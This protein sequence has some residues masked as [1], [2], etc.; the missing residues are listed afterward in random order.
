MTTTVA[1][2]KRLNAG[3]VTDVR[4]A[5]A[6]SLSKD[7]LSVIREVGLEPVLIDQPP[8]D[9]TS[10]AAVV[11]PGGGDI[12]PARYGGRQVPQLYDVDLEQDAL[13]FHVA[14]Q[15]LRLGLPVLGICRGFQILNILHGGTLFEHLESSDVQHYVSSALSASSIT[16]SLS[17]HEVS[18]VDSTCLHEELGF[19]DPLVASGHHQ[20]IRTLGA[21]LIP[22]AHAADGLI[23]AFE[24]SA[25]SAFGVQWHPE[26]VPSGAA[27]L[28][29]F[30]ALARAT[31]MR[32]IG[33]SL[34]THA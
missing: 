7:V 25:R 10:F 16:E 22:S 29:P 9:L 31:E 1:V 20:G 34:T 15:A 28:A 30:R 18:V 17:W 4:A 33:P 26:L 11:L 5:I 13:D 23:E 24:N 8:A 2:P 14:S 12:D 3:S 27:R 21:G 32:R 6:E 19:G